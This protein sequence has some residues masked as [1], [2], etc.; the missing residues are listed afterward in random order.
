MRLC[1]VSLVVF[2]DVL[3][4]AYG[5]AHFETVDLPINESLYKALNKEYHCPL[6]R[7]ALSSVTLS[8]QGKASLNTISIVTPPMNHLGTG[9]PQKDEDKQ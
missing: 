3:L 7:Y 9:C 5:H 6:D 2:L 4:S 1:D 8:I